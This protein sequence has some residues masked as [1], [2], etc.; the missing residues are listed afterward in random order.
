MLDVLTERYDNG[1]IPRK[2]NE[3]PVH[4]SAGPRS[5]HANY[6]E[7]AQATTVKVDAWGDLTSIRCR[8]QAAVGGGNINSIK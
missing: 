5:T 3:G 6:D 8:T 4:S 2:C 7:I 1:T